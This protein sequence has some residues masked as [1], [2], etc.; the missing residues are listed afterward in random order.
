MY[1]YN[2]PIE[3][4]VYD[5]NNSARTLPKTVAKIVPYR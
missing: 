2:T 1:F 5:F 4:G 3:G